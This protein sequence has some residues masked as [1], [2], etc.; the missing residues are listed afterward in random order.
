MDTK[1]EIKRYLYMILACV[2][3]AFG[4]YFFL[5][6]NKDLGIISGGFGGLAQILNDYLYLGNYAWLAILNFPFVVIAFFMLGKKFT[7]NCLITIVTLVGVSAIFEIIRDKFD[8]RL[9][10]DA[11]V[12]CIY[13]GLCQGIAIGIYCKYRVSS[14]G[15]ELVGR[16]LQKLT[17]KLTIPIYSGILDA[18]VMGLGAW[19]LHNISVIFYSLIL[20]FIVTKVSDLVI[21]GFHK[22]K[23]CYV[24]TT[25]PDEVGDFLVHNSPRGVTKLDGMGMYQ[26][27]YRGV[28]MTVVRNSQV[29]TLKQWVKAL[30]ENAFVIVSDTNEVLGNGFKKIGDD[31][32]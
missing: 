11:L 31:E 26:H 16:F 13:G 2:I 7:I 6:P 12:A 22:S 9:V 15:T 3:Y 10:E 20:V 21:V 8:V 19:H 4:Y 29:E 25:K 5:V 24:I 23:L 30:D 1:Y 17:G 32:K 18:I 14:G 28:L 27:S